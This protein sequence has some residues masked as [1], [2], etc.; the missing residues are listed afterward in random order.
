M[1]QLGDT[2]RQRRISLGLSLEQAEADTKI[3]ARL[4]DALEEGDYGKLPN[5]GYVRGYVSSYARYLELDP[6]PLLAMY[7]AE[8]GAG[9]FHDI[10]LPD[11]AVTPRH[12]QHAVPWRVPILALVIVVIVSLGVWVV[13]QALRGPQKPPPIPATPSQTATSTANG[14]GAPAAAKPFVLKVAVS[15]NGASAVKVTIDGRVAYDGTLTAGQ[16][17]EFQVAGSAVVIVGKPSQVTVTR[18]GK[19]VALGRKTPATVTLAAGQ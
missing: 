9:R 17:K 1:G 5:P 7:R 12:Q 18:D 4:L 6:V 13:S 10:N 2:L 19:K 16:Q 11:E 8:T 15:R 14:P 3:R